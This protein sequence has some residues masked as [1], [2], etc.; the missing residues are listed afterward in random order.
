MGKDLYKRVFINDINNPKR[1]KDGFIKEHILVVG[2]KIGRYLKKEE[3]VHH[4]DENKKNNDPSNLMIFATNADHSRFHKG[5]YKEL[6]CIDNVWKCT[7]NP[8]LC[9]KCGKKID[10]RTKTFECLECIKKENNHR[11]VKNR[12]SKE[13]LYKLLKE[14]TF[15]EVGR[16]YGVA[17]N[18]IRKWCKRYDIPHKASYYR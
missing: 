14:N 10:R 2:N 18:T 11:K 17:D 8:M 16:M 13:E 5:N 9:I 3:V 6:I 1:C 4:I 7:E 12:P 15:T